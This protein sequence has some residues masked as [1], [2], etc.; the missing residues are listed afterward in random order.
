[1]D[2]IFKDI[3][4]ANSNILLNVNFKQQTTILSHSLDL[5]KMS[6]ALKSPK[7]TKLYERMS[8]LLVYF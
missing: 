2:V 8:S 7:M 1:M 3:K 4:S 5:H 6:G